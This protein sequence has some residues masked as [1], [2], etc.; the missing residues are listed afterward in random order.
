MQIGV[1]MN[2]PDPTDGFTGDPERA[3]A[4]TLTFRSSG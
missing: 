3:K 1:W 2:N 4:P